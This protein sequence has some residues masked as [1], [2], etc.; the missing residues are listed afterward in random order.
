[1]GVSWYRL[2]LCL[3]LL[4][5]VF[6]VIS[7]ANW[8]SLGT[9]WANQGCAG[10]VRA[11]ACDSISLSQGVWWPAL[12]GSLALLVSGLALAALAHR[13]DLRAMRRIAH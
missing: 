1:M 4:G 13:A 12:V 8:S 3:L 10:A 2:G 11:S 9:A 7:Y 6:S 5:A